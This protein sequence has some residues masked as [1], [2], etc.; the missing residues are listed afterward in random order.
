[1]RPLTS[2][3]GDLTRNNNETGLRHAWIKPIGVPYATR[4]LQEEMANMLC[5]LVG[6]IPPFPEALGGLQAIGRGQSIGHGR[7][8]S[9]QPNP[10]LAQSAPSSNS[11]S[12]DHRP[13]PLVLLEEETLL[14]KAPLAEPGVIAGKAPLAE[15]GVIKV[16]YDAVQ[17]NAQ[18]LWGSAVEGR[19]DTQQDTTHNPHHD[20][21]SSLPAVFYNAG[22]QQVHVEHSTGFR[23]VHH[24]RGMIKCLDECGTCFTFGSR[25]PHPG[26]MPAPDKMRTCQQKPT[27][28]PLSLHDTPP[29]EPFTTQLPLAPDH[30]LAPHEPSLAAEHDAL[31]DQPHTAQLRFTLAKASPTAPQQPT[32]AIRQPTGPPRAPLPAAANKW[33]PPPPTTPP[34]LLLLAQTNGQDGPE[35]LQPPPPT[36]IPPPL[37]DSVCD[38]AKSSPPKGTDVGEATNQ[39]WQHHGRTLVDMSTQGSSSQYDKWP[40]DNSSAMVQARSD[41]YLTMPPLT[42][43]QQGVEQLLLP[44]HRWFNI[45]G[46]T[47]TPYQWIMSLFRLNTPIDE[48]EKRAAAIGHTEWEGFEFHCAVLEILG[49]VKTYGARPHGPPAKEKLLKD[50]SEKVGSFTHPAQQDNKKHRYPSLAPLSVDTDP[51]LGVRFD[52]DWHHVDAFM[53]ILMEAD[54]A[55]PGDHSGKWQLV[56]SYNYGSHHGSFQHASNIHPF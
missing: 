4:E 49:N 39:G 44:H 10:V 8:S 9:V 20:G 23:E 7:P 26:H 40:L 45:T 50:L 27:H 28:Q 16:L 56:Q 14:C 17:S 6:Y 51:A 55:E 1:M 47:R 22:S 53:R 38:I 3:N 42:G 18:M 33:S 29:G 21:S 25:R 24:V 31:A 41:H 54:V 36:T 13:P 35:H 32:T 34:P 5:S 30:M 52:V 43:G 37:S 15:P 2:Y 12:Q 19:S 46:Q 48:I 11:S